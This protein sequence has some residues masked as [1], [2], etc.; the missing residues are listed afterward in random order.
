MSRFRE[1][2]YLSLSSSNTNMHGEP[3]EMERKEPYVSRERTSGDNSP[4]AVLVYKHDIEQPSQRRTGRLNTNWDPP[5]LRRWVLVLFAS[6][7]VAIIAGLQAVYSVSVK[8]QGIAKSNDNKHYLWTYGPTAI[9]VVLTVLWRQV[10]Y[11]AK[12]IQPWAE[13]AKGPQP[14]QDSL[15]LDYVTPFQLFSLWKSLRKGHIAV[16]SSIAV[17][18]LIKIITIVSTST[19]EL[20]SIQRDGVA[21]TMSLNTTFDGSSFNHAASVDSRAVISVY[22]AN[23]Y[24]VSLPVGTTDAYAVQTFGPAAGF[25][26]GSLTY[27]ATV[28]VFSA[29]LANCTTGT[30]NHTLGY[31]RSYN[32]PVS[33]YYNTSVSLPDCEIHNAN[34]RAPSWYW[35]TNDTVH[36]FGYVGSLQNVSC[37]N[38]AEDDPTRDRYMLSAAYSEGFSQD[39][40][41]MLNSS[42]IVCTPTY[43]IQSGVVTLDTNGNIQSVDLTGKPRALDDVSGVDIAKGVLTSATN[44]YSM[45]TS[46]NT[47]VLDPFMTLMQEASDNFQVTQLLDPAYLTSVGN[48]AFGQASAQLARVY[49]LTTPS[50]NSAS[51]IDGTVSE[52]QNRLVARAAPVRAMQGIAAGML[53]LTLVMLFCTPRGVVP[54][55]IDSIAAVAAILARSPALEARLRGTGHMSLDQLSNLLSPYRFMTSVG[56]EDGARSFSIRMSTA[57]EVHE[58]TNEE[59]SIFHNV[60]WI[61]PFILRRI[62][63]ALTMLASIAA[64]IVLEVLL[65]QS[66]AHDGL[67]NVPGQKDATRYSW[68]YVP[69]LV[70]VLLGTLFNIMDFEIEFAESYHAMAK[71]FCNANSSMLWYPLRHISL[72]ATWNGLRHSRFALTAASTSAILAPFLTIVVSGLFIAQPTVKTTLLQATALNWFNTTNPS[73]S[74]S[75]NI[76]S[77]VIEGNMSY[78]QWTYDELAIP[79]IKVNQ[80]I[81]HTLLQNTSISVSTPAI[82]AAVS[83]YVVPQDRL[84]NITI[85]NKGGNAINI[86]MAAG[87]GNS[88]FA[89]RPFEYLIANPSIP[90]N[91]SGY[92]GA[93]DAISGQY[94]YCPTKALFYGHMTENNVLDNF[95]AYLCTQGLERVN[96]NVTF[97]LPDMTISTAPVV[98]PGSAVNFSSYRPQS[99]TL[100]SLNLT[101]VDVLDSVFE[102]MV[103]GRDGIPMN[104]LANQTKLMDTFTHFYRQYMAQVVNQYLRADFSTLSNNATETVADPLRATYTNARNMRVV[105]SSLSTQLLVGVLVALL[106]CAATIFVT[107]DMR[108]VLPKPMGS[109]A[110]VASLL[111]GSRIVDETSGLIPKGSEYWS[112]KDWEKSGIWQG[113]MFRMGWWGKFDEPVNSWK[114]QRDMMTGT[115]LVGGDESENPLSASDTSSVRSFRIDARP[116]NII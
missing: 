50:A 16:A 28:D 73:Y 101:A 32:T 24:N 3:I 15:L 44:S 2:D 6:F 97:D 90:V 89:D 69:V 21:T 68:L 37:S 27:T 34:L 113:E 7:S 103:Y 66:R 22:A 67:G 91:K 104:E 9:F 11:A 4:D 29:S 115:Y 71:G 20:T 25:I 100:L 70:F 63:I 31:D 107:I 102:A 99:L 45:A 86:S 14:V 72:H 55:A 87:C 46:S 53:V 80:S 35:Q 78:P 77:L 112:D 43:S 47:L 82:R 40:F 54:R 110:A 75:T 116:R 56:Y 26:N 108:H 105:Q 65:S 64:I 58:L 41:T 49:L 92:F 93:S 83:C 84:L 88:G 33:G 36:R 59:N 95:T 8:N 76:P 62:A 74:T 98:D 106:I 109:V 79:R 48:K 42:N 10:D 18:F 57:S 52:F 23:Q 60:K 30:I 13:M 1:H 96:A 17:F 39:N 114:G 38:L 111:A 85:P 5:F 51:T 81:E 61:Q 94:D 12:S 19:F